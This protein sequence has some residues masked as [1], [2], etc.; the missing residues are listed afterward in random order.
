MWQSRAEACVLGLFRRSSEIGFLVSD[1]LFAGVSRG[2]SP[3][4]GLFQ[5]TFAVNAPAVRCV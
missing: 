2:Q 5:T 1:D 4:Y 3:R